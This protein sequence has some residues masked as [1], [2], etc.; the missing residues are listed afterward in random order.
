MKQIFQNEFFR[1][2]SRELL[3]SLY[4]A[5]SMIQ[6]HNLSRGLIAESILRHFLKTILP[7]KVNVTQGFIE[8]D[9]LLSPQCDII[10]YDNLNYAPLFTYGEVEVI[11]SKAVYAVIEIKTGINRK[12][13]GKVLHDFET[14]Y[15]MG[16]LQKYLFIYNGRSLKTIKKYFWGKYVPNYGRKQNEP[17]YDY[18]NFNALPKAIVSINPDYYFKQ[19]YCQ[20]DNDDMMGYMAFSITDNSDKEIASIQSFIKDLIEQTNLMDIEEYEPPTLVNN[21]IPNL[22]D[23][24]KELKVNEGIPLFRM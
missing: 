5:Q 17:L 20:T 16:V 11:P 1:L 18:D 7:Q 14:L 3:F 22:Q 8:C 13:F 2:K 15:L 12:E 6:N 4:Q 24:M 21:N 10:I 23:N 19:G 9:G